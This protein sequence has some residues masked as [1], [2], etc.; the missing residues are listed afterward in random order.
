VLFTQKKSKKGK[1]VGKPIFVGYEINFSTAMNEATTR[2]SSNF[3]VDQLV[4]KT[5]KRK[6]VHVLKPVRFTIT[7][8]TSNSVTLKPAGYQNFPKGG[9]IVINTSTP[10]GVT[11]SSGVYLSGSGVIAITP[12]G[13]GLTLVSQ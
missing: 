6:K 13:K 7:G 1:P 2:S 8:V 12:G 3:V 9:M 11:S 4:I 10:S 5:V